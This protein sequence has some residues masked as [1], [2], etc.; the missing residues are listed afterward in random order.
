MEND[1][2]VEISLDKLTELWNAANVHSVNEY[3][4]YLIEDTE[5]DENGEPVLPGDPVEV[6]DLVILLLTGGTD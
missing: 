1:N 2:V 5:T 4:E 6:I 3:G